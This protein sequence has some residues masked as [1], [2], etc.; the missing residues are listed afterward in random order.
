MNDLEEKANEMLKNL[1]K[2][3]FDKYGDE[4]AEKTLQKL[5]YIKNTLESQEQQITQ[6]TLTQREAKKLTS[7]RTYIKN[8]KAKLK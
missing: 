7:L 6:P 2:V 1:S 3:G 8:A 4:K 5:D